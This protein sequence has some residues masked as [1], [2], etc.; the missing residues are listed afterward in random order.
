[1]HICYICSEYPPGP[2]GGVGTFTQ[3]LG[4]A[5]VKRGHNV[6][7]VGFGLRNQADFG[8]HEDAGVT[9]IRLRSSTVPKFGAISS[10]LRL[11][12]TL[13]RVNAYR[14]IDVL[15]GP[16]LSL[17][18]LPRHLLPAQVI[19]MH[20]GHHFFCHDLGLKKQRVRSWL[21][22]RSFSNAGCLCAVSQHVAKTTSELL[23][24][25]QRNIEIL[26]NPVDTV[27]FAPQPS[28][29]E[30]PCRIMFVGTICEKKGVRQLLEAMPAI[31]Q[32]DSRVHLQIVGR[33]WYDPA[34]G[35]NYADEM[36]RVAARLGPGRV[37]FVG[38]VKNSDLPKLLASAAVCVMPSHA[39][40]MSL[41]WLE[42]LSVGR[43]VVA[44]RIGPGPEVVEDGVSGLLCD[45]HDPQSIASCVSDLIASPE[46]RRR[47]GQAA[48][49]RVLERFSTD[50]LVLRNEEFYSRC[51]DQARANVN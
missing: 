6:T 47:L 25:Q 48:R 30:V 3:T 13:Q 18:L 43:P 44:S 29:A 23:D 28:V 21:E 36:R 4:R 34:T 1:M 5:L 10:S 40:A 12:R 49:E 27:H 8:Q 37:N 17:A 46:L 33:D 35:E 45:P 22:R 15:E 51:V 7:V 50:A 42:A 24:L 32:R 2:H 9:V 38:T 19:R 39:E 41:T 11:Q 26:P 14:R 20:G 31:L 16:E